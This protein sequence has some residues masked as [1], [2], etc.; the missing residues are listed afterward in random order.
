MCILSLL[1]LFKPKWK[2]SDPKVRR[3]ALEGVWSH[4]VL[5]A[6]VRN[7]ENADVRKAAVER[8][9]DDE[10]LARLAHTS[11]DVVVRL[12]A[13][14]KIMDQDALS[15]IAHNDKDADVRK[16]A[17]KRQEALADIDRATLES[18]EKISLL[19]LAVP[20][21]RDISLFSRIVLKNNMP[22][23]FQVR[24]SAFTDVYGKLIRSVPNFE[25]VA[26]GSNPFYVSAE[27]GPCRLFCSK[28]RLLL[29]GSFIFGLDAARAFRGGVGGGNIEAGLAGV[30]P[31][32]GGNNAMI[33]YVPT[34]ST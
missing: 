11:K 1:D 22:I 2:H 12:A 33:L 23:C 6:I 21:V 19:G 26:M 10:I 13:I 31:K 4:D 34:T 29:P 7:D 18:S 27:H 20:V 25:T 14:E 9:T 15:A 5:S 3:K 17:D 32:C 16:A 28:C 8:M 24:I 30:C